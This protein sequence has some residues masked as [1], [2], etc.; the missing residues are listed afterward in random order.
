VED[1]LQHNLLVVRGEEMKTKTWGCL[2]DD[3]VES[4]V[5]EWANVNGIVSYD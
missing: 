5:Q 4:L 3:D 1:F 2:S